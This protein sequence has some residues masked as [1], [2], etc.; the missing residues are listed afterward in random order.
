M[1]LQ[2][3]S[4]RHNNI[5]YCNTRRSANVCAKRHTEI[6]R[7]TKI[8]HKICLVIFAETHCS[9]IPRQ[10][11]Q[12]VSA[13]LDR[14]RAVFAFKSAQ[15]RIIIYNI[16]YSMSLL[17]LLYFT[18]FIHFYPSRHYYAWHMIYYIESGKFGMRSK[19]A[20]PIYKNIA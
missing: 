4:R 6:E 10:C 16:L 20:V 19:R 9:R 1:S 11:G 3:D 14:R 7:I 8:R 12:P 2:T 13:G 17:L 5:L 18:N 15:I